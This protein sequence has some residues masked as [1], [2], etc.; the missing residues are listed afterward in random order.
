[1]QNVK[2]RVRFKGVDSW[3]RPVFIDDDKNFYGSTDILF[4]Y[5]ASE[6]EV[7]DKVTNS[8][9][10][11]FGRSFGCEPLGSPCNVEIVRKEYTEAD[12][13][14]DEPVYP[15]Y[16]WLKPNQSRPRN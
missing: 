12:A 11:Y 3:N 2:T 5:G 16:S 14:A 13:L 7:L 1:M 6:S 10:T 4:S 8:D 15:D 9:L